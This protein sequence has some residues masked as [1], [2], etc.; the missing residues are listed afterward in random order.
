MGKVSHCLRHWLVV[1]AGML[2]ALGCNSENLPNLGKVTGKITFDGK[3]LNNAIVEFDRVDASVAPAF[4]KTDT[5]GKYELYY[6][7][8]AKGATVGEHKVLVTAFADAGESGKATKEFVPAKYNV[9]SELK[10][11]VKRG[12]N[13]INFDLKPGGDIIQPNTETKAARTGC[14]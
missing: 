9:M 6:S 5:E 11:T 12:A 8:A 14:F 10:A 4:G 1:C 2:A 7:R 13:E 3:P